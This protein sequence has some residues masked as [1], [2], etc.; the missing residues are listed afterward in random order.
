MKKIF[1]SDRNG[2]SQDEEILP[3]DAG[4]VHL[5]M[6]AFAGIVLVNIKKNAIES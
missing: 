3:V 1:Y 4:E 5:S 2:F 6:G